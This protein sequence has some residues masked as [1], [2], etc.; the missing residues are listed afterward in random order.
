[1]LGLARVVTE[2]QKDKVNEDIYR[3]LIEMIDHPIKV[4]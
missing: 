1:M 3:R 2:G 4:R